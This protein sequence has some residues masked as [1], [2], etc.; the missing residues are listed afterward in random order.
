MGGIEDKGLIKHVRGIIVLSEDVSD[1]FTSKV[2]SQFMITKD[3]AKIRII[4]LFKPKSV[5]EY[6]QDCGNSRKGKCYGK[7][8]CV[9]FPYS[10]EE[11]C[12]CPPGYDGTYCNERSNTTFSSTL[13]TLM[14]ATAKVPQL[15]DVYFELEDTRAE[16]RNGLADVGKALLQMKKFVSKELDKLSTSMTK[17]FAIGSF[18]TKY[19][20][21]IQEMSAAI[22]ISKPLFG[23]FN[24]SSIFST[25]PRMR[26]QAIKYAETYTEPD[27][28]PSWEITL[29]DMFTAR[30][31]F[32]I[33]ALKPLMIL[34]IDIYKEN[35]CMPSYKERIDQLYRNFALL[36]ADLFQL[37]VSALYVL[38]VDPTNIGKTYKARVA[39]QV[40]V[41][42]F[43]IRHLYLL[44]LCTIAKHQQFQNQIF[45]EYFYCLVYLK[46][47]P[48]LESNC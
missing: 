42:I 19:A 37:H 17:L 23:V 45:I 38:D 11:Q 4:V 34:A 24:K 40:C 8:K 21:K 32:S 41:C 1:S 43:L 26:Q 20:V 16:M 10:T 39:S 18:Q 30:S 35:A 12:Q 47:S 7:S 33:A 9:K 15:S 5:V 28:I 36:Q 48:F 6:D 25:S 44:Y 2:D 29:S 13:D 22:E 14:T 3:D 31:R 27:K 46:I